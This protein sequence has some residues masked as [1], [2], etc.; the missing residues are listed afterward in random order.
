MT[1]EHTLPSPSNS[2]A[3]KAGQVREGETLDIKALSQWLS[4]H[5]PELSGQPEI[6]QYSGGASNWTYCLTFPEAASTSVI[7]RRAPAGTKAKGAH[8]MG[9]EY[10]LQQALKPAY[11]LVPDMIAHCDDTSIIGSEFYLMEKLNGIIPR[12]NLPRGLVLSEQQVRLLCLNAIDSLI[13]LHSVDIEQANLTHLGKGEGYIERQI[14]GWTKRYTQ[15]RTWNVPKAHKVINWLENNLPD[16]ERICLTHNDFRFDNLVLSPDDPIQIIGVLDWE[17]ATL[18]DPLMDLGNSLAY[19]VEAQDDFMA[20]STRR[21]PTHLNGM[22]RRDE[23]ID[24]YLERTGLDS[25][26]FTFYQVYGLFRLAGIVQQIYYRY[27]HGQ[28]RNP[29]FKHIWLYVHYLLYRC[30]KLMKR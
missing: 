19:W 14:N 9:R 27:H 11:P 4:D 22:L 24:Y 20:K 1:A 28:T 10:R 29:A 30:N 18:G 23:V 16:R 5:V 25:V 15:A 3:D 2:F 8:D 21:Q 26:D 17:L 13:H 12:K 6:T 7:L